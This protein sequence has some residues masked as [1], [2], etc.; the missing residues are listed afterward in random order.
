MK[1]HFLHMDLLKAIALPVVAACLALV[2]A[3]SFLS[4]RALKK[5]MDSQIHIAHQ[6]V[7]INYMAKKSKNKHTLLAMASESLLAIPAFNNIHIIDVNKQIVFK[8]G[9]PISIPISTLLKATQNTDIHEIFELDNQYFTHFLVANETAVILGINKTL[10]KA[11][12]YEGLIIILCVFFMSMITLQLCLSAFSRSL[13]HSINILEQGVS[14]LIGYNYDKKI[15]HIN[16]KAF[17]PLTKMINKL[18][19]IQK[20]ISEEAINDLERSTL[21]L[22]ETLET[23]ERQN[24]ELDI[25]KKSATKE[26]RIKSRFLAN[27]SHEVRTPLNGIM[28]FTRLLKKTSLDIQQKEYLYTIEQ[29]AEGLLTTMNDILDFSKLDIGTLNL[30]YKPIKLR[31]LMNETLLQY[32]KISEEKNLQ[33]LTFID[34]NIPEQLLG[35]PLRLKQILGNIISNAIKFSENGNIIITV[36][37]DQIIKNH[38]SLRFTITDKGMGISEELHEKIFNPFV[39]LDTSENRLNGGIGLGLAITKGLIEKMHGSIHVKSQVNVGTEV[40]FV[41]AIGRNLNVNQSQLFLYDSLRNVHALIYN[42]CTEKNEECNHYLDGW[43]VTTTQASSLA[44]MIEIGDN[45]SKKNPVTFVIIDTYNDHSLKDKNTLIQHIINIEVAL[46]V[47]VFIIAKNSVQRLLEPMLINT[48][49]AFI[50]RPIFSTALHSSICRK[51]NIQNKPSQIKENIFTQ[52]SETMTETLQVMVV[53]DN[54]ANLKLVSELL[55]ELNTQVISF[56]SGQ[57]ALDGFASAH[58]DI[59]FMDIQMPIMDGFETTTKLRTLEKNKKNINRTPIIAL[60]AHAVSEQKK[61]LLL[62]GL[63]DALSKPVNEA[64]LRH[65]IEKWT[66]K[67]LEVTSYYAPKPE[68]NITTN[69]KNIKK[70][71]KVVDISQ[72][73][74]LTNNNAKLAAE[75][76]EMLIAS[77]DDTL[78][79]I[80]TGNDLNSIGAAAHKLF[81]GCCYTGV[82][83]LRKAAKDVDVAIKNGVFGDIK[84]QI[85]TLKKEI[86]L[87]KQWTEEHD[88]SALFSE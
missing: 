39:Q 81:G 74:K 84:K 63:D 41:V 21:E 65:T 18:S 77:L 73:I 78:N 66:G 59:I 23:V 44:K 83:R 37:K 33:I 79:T 22:R 31:E 75:M 56:D 57:K 5:N 85:D 88:I 28:G 58:F 13:M 46:D 3:F 80:S 17:Q 2:I 6:L 34:H 62:A 51:L 53:D 52:R 64:E 76:L 61:E 26:S 35:D 54:H 29:S 11:N 42:E 20:N 8:K 60:T 43:G 48:K 16:I 68:E 1:N 69:P 27:T 12:R 87:L 45:L 14:N 30:E 24:I 36:N 71:L 50:S 10:F 82:P 4:A 67:Q 32:V 15:K 86:L 47:P 70:E 55:K 40:S 25:A 72:S 38:F 49:H 9:L 19:D 7:S